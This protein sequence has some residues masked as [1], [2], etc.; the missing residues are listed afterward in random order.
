MH[1]V[2]A[3]ALSLHKRGYES[4]PMSI[5]ALPLQGKLPRGGSIFSDLYQRSPPTP[6]F[7]TRPVC[8]QH[9]KPH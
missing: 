5:S 4:I 6:A 1:A 8:S 7:T 9:C 3:L 2:C